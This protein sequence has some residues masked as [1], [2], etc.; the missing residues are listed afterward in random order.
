VYQQ[1]SEKPCWILNKIGN[2]DGCAIL[3]TCKSCPWFLK[4]NPHLNQKQ[5]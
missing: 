1:S 2:T 3:G 5:E 4:N